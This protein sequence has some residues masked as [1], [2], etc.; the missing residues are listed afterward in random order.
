MKRITNAEAKSITKP[1][2]HRADDTLYLCVK[3][4]GRRSWLQRVVISGRRHTLGL[5][6]YP[7]VT[8]AEARDL[9]LDNRRL[10][11]KGGNPLTERRRTQMPTF[12]VATERTHKQFKPSWK[13]KQHAT[14]WMQ[15]VQKHAFPILADIPVDQITQQDVLNVLEPI[16]TTKPETA[17]RVRQRIRSVLRYCQAHNFVQH[18]V[19]DERIDGALAP[20][21]KVKEHHAAI[22]Y[23]EV[24]EAFK[25]IGSRFSPARLALRFLILTATRSNEV[26]E[27][28][29]NEIDFESST[30]TIPKERMK[31]GKEHR[32]PITGPMNEVLEQARQLSDDSDLIFPSVSK[33]G[34]PMT[35][36]NLMKV[37][38]KMPMAKDT[39]VHGFRTS[40]RV[41]GAECTAVPREVLELALAHAVGNHVEQAYSRSDMLKKR[42]ELMERWSE[43]VAG[44]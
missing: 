24:P 34:H 21:P 6:P 26:R 40:F 28:T 38:R 33:P 22:D 23:R 1:G 18:N 30:W 8:L 27:A 15:V 29:W 16:W 42:V 31:G 10:I 25:V 17:R 2:L 4:S 43:F 5:G 13:N 32:V 39:T 41:W 36:D 9:A 12:R 7:V 35:P 19:A 20:M 44:P 11:R 37:W 3:P 14:S